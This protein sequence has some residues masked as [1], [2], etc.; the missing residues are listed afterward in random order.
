MRI[1]DPK[2]SILMYMHAG[3]ANHG[4]EAIVRSLCEI[5]GADVNLSVISN[6]FDQDKKAGI[7]SVCR[8]IPVKRFDD[9]FFHKVKFYLLRHIKGRSDDQMR[10]AYGGVSEVERYR[11]ALSI[12]GDNYCYPDAIN[13]LTGA[14]Y[15]FNDIGIPTSLVG[16]SIDPSILKDPKILKDM[17]LYRDI[18]ARESETY[19]ALCTAFPEDMHDVLHLIPD[20]AFV[21]IPK[22]CELP[23]GLHKGHIIGINVSP[24][25][26]DYET[27]DNPGITMKNYVSLIQTILDETHDDIMLIPHV[28]MP[29]SDDRGPLKQLYERFSS[30]GRVYMVGDR[31]AP[32]LK[33][34]ISNCRLMITA[35]THA[36]I[37]AYSTYVPTLV[38]GYSVKAAGIAK[39]LFGAEMTDKDLY[40][41]GYLCPVQNLKTDH[42]LTDAYMNLEANADTMRDRLHEVIPGVVEAVYGIRDILIRD[43]E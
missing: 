5:L 7:D 16:C 34:I 39:D 38:V 36:S 4:C 43:T 13:D 33:Y 10:Y 18:I 24:M 6:N 31:T 12:G 3:S 26:I 21:L 11:E 15:M 37:A 35:R 2:N 42:D 28:T 23:G 29:L 9:T 22:E 8:I 30:S 19:N 27:P 25:I 17:M 20:P 14:N 40:A 32:E 41:G 1:S